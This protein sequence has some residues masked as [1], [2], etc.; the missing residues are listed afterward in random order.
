MS[1]KL[2]RKGKMSMNKYLDDGRK[3]VLKNKGY[4]H[5]QNNVKHERKVGEPIKG[6]ETKVPSSWLRKGYVEAK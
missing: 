5:T 4:E 6:F 3:F 1:E 2:N